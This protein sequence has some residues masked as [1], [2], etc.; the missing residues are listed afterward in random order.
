[1][2]L[3]KYKPV[4]SELIISNMQPAEGK[5]IQRALAPKL[6][7]IKPLSVVNDLTASITT[8]Y[9]IAGQQADHVTLALYV[10][11]FY[12]KLIETYPTVTVEEV[13]AAI[14]SGVYGEYGDF[15]GINPKTLI[16]FVRA[17]LR[18]EERK[19]AKEKFEKTVYD[20]EKPSVEQLEKSNQDFSNMLYQDFLNRKLKWEYIPSF[21]YD[22]MVYR[23]CFDLC[24][25][26]KNS[27]HKQAGKILKQEKTEDKLANLL[28]GKIEHELSGN[29]ENR[30]TII[31]KELAVVEYFS[32]CEI[33][34]AETIFKN[35]KE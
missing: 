5:F 34:N 10:D 13:K 7:D 22:F 20:D 2:Q 16:F 32:M 17:Y 30:Q 15:Y 33:F 28:F 3:V 26:T 31:A 27:L 21:I 6:K 14:R 1:M 11:E 24:N 25:R 35:D 9:T 23:G 8:A 18:S 19:S 4:A 12:K 29:S